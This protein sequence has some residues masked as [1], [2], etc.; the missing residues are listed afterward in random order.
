MP[1]YSDRMVALRLRPTATLVEYFTD[2]ALSCLM[3]STTQEETLKE[4]AV[5][6]RKMRLFDALVA[7]CCLING[8]IV[9]R[10]FREEIK[11][12]I[13]ACHFVPH[14]LIIKMV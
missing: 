13:N 7:S 10:E 3:I 2:C 4:K 1:Q 14:V 11:N 9:N 12:Q 6:E 5:L 8:R